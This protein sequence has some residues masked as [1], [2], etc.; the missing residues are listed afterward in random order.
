MEYKV[1]LDNKTITMY[2]EFTY[3]QFVDMF[4]RYSDY[5]FVMNVE[6]VEKGFGNNYYPSNDDRQP[7]NPNQ[8]PQAPQVWY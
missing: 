2:G 4:E 6:R 5:K 7:Y 8:F 3:Q 1:N